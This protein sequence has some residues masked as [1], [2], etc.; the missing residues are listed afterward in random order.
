MEEEQEEEEVVQSEEETPSEEAPTLP[1]FDSP[2]N[3]TGGANASRTEEE[4]PQS[5]WSDPTAPPPTDGEEEEF[6]NAVPPEYEDSNE[7]GSAMAL[8][9]EPAVLPT[10]LPPVLLEL[11]WLP[12]RPP[13][14]YDGFNVYVYRDG[15]T[16]LHMLTAVPH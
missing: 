11:R 12:P 2:L 9:A 1:S 5:S 6:V 15:K 4:E 14:S 13:T 7:P 10:K 3:L 16:L 8:P